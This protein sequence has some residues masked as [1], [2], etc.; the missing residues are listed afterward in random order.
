MVLRFG[1]LGANVIR[2][3]PG[4]RLTRTITQVTI[5]VALS[6]CGAAG[7]SAQDEGS[8]FVLQRHDRTIVVEPYAPNIVRITLS[9]G[10]AAASAAPG[11]GIIGT[12]S[13]T[14]WTYARDAAGYDVVRSPRL[15]IHVSPENLPQPRGM[16]LDPLNESLREKYFGDGE[17]NARPTS[18]N[19]AISIV[20]ESGKPLLTLGGWS[21]GPNK[22]EAKS[23][24]TQEFST[25]PRVSIITD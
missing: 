13:K 21:M 5:M 24:N 6:L 2:K 23:A 9:T 18:Y 7:A 22:P 19:D 20:T 8:S 14:D 10:R 3:F 15:T 11:Y 16:P 4:A 12:P 17:G 1:C 25:R